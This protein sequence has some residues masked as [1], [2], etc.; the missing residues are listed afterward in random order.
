MSGAADVRSPAHGVVPWSPWTMNAAVF[1]PGTVA[2]TGDRIVAVGPATDLEGVTA[3]R[4]IDVAGR[5]IIPGFTDC[6][7]HLFQFLTRG[8]GEGM[9]LWPWLAEFMWRVSTSI[10]RDE[11]IAAARLGALEAAKGGTTA[12]L[13]HHYAPTDLETTVGVAAAIEEVGPARR[14]GARHDRSGHGGGAGAEPRARDVPLLARRRA[15]DHAQRDQGAAGGTAW[16][17]WPGAAEHHLRRA[18]ARAPRGGARARVGHRMARALL[19]VPHGSRS[20]TRHITA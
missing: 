16:V 18:G 3:A 15:V 10:T 6:H 9:E 5:A 20:R 13:D 2:I 1:D 14:R 12:I 8:L 11:A 4:T 17:V 7:N 19:R